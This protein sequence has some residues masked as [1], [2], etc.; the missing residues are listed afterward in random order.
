MKNSASHRSLQTVLLGTPFPPD[1]F[2]ILCLKHCLSSFVLPDSPFW[3]FYLSVH[4]PWTSLYE[5]ICSNNTTLKRKAKCSS[6]VGF[7]YMILKNQTDVS[8]TSY[9]SV[10]NIDTCLGITLVFYIYWWQLQWL[11]LTLSDDE[12]SLKLCEIGVMS[13]YKCTTES[14]GASAVLDAQKL[15]TIYWYIRCFSKYAINK[16]LRW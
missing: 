7:V 11:I 5:G 8:V 12:V 3:L 16:L 9:M 10:L 1:S 15:L 2:I 13:V 4:L 6:H 14:F